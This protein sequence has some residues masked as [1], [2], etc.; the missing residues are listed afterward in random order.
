MHVIETC[1]EILSHFVSETNVIIDT[2][3]LSFI[4]F[5]TFSPPFLSITYARVINVMQKIMKIFSSCLLQIFKMYFLLFFLVFFGIFARLWDHIFMT[6]PKN[7]HFFSPP[8][9]PTID[10]LY[11]INRFYPPPPFRDVINVSARFISLLFVT[12]SLS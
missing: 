6:S 9:P 1:L 2:E 8:P 10:L 7:C 5:Y 12:L 4:P 3:K 11:Y